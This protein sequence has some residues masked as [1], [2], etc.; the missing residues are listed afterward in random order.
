[1]R[2]TTDDTFSYTIT[3][4]RAMSTATVTITTHRYQ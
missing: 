1:M 3:D 2:D 4:S